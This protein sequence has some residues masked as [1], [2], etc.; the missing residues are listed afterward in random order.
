MPKYLKNELS[1]KAKHLVMNTNVTSSP[2]LFTCQ[3]PPFDPKF[4]LNLCYNPAELCVLHISATASFP[5]TFIGPHCKNNFSPPQKI[6]IKRELSRKKKEKLCPHI[7]LARQ[8]QQ[9]LLALTSH[10]CHR[11]T[12]EHRPSTSH[13]PTPI[14]SSP[15]H[16]FSPPTTAPSSLIKMK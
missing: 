15:I 3:I 16:A 1:L 14:F 11:Q 7:F 12:T 2:A 9:L 6:K 5:A 4:S 8:R 13:R 10:A